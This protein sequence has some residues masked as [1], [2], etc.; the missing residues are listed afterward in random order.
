MKNVL[1]LLENLF[2]GDSR[3]ELLVAYEQPLHTHTDVIKRSRSW[4]YF[5]Q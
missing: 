2:K 3:K 1:K 5:R 4:L